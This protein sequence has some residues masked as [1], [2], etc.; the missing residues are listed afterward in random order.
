MIV[1]CITTVK[2]ESDV[3]ILIAIPYSAVNSDTTDFPVQIAQ[4]CLSVTPSGKTKREPPLYPG[5]VLF[6]LQ[7]HAT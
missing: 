2:L 4:L 3:Q 1:S 6:Y 7:E 5:S